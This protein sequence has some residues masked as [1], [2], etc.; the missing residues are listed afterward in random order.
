MKAV[1]RRTVL[2]GMAVLAPLPL[3]RLSR[4]SSDLAGLQVMTEEYPPYNYQVG[5]ELMGLSVEIMEEI[6]NRTASGHSRSD[7]SLL[8]WARGYNLTLQRSGHALFSTTR[9]PDRESLFKWVGPFVPTVVG[10]IAKKSRNLNIQTVQDLADLRIG[11]VKDDIGQLLLQAKGV[12]DDRIEA[13]LS[14]DQNFRKLIAG[15]VD[16]ISYETRV[17]RWAL[18]TRDVALDEY[19]TVYELDRGELY[20]ALHHQTP[21]DLVGLLQSVFD[22]MV[23]DGTHAQILQRYGIKS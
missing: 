11:V 19:E 10:L 20:L 17:T 21:D 7:I 9:T 12:P 2:A 15:R 23:D 6:F 1:T 5:G 8:P 14:N 18:Q 16:A 22:T 13:V 4:A 3:L